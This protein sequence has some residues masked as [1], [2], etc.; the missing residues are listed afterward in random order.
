MTARTLL[1]PCLSLLTLSC[2]HPNRVSRSA[3]QRLS[4][5]RVPF[6]LV[7][8]SVSTPAKA[9]AHPTIRFAHP[10]NTTGPEYTL[11]SLVIGNGDRFFAVLQAQQGMPGLD[12]FYA[13]VG[14]SETGF[15]KVLY[16]RLR[17]A[18]PPTAMYVGEISV[19]PAENR[20]QRDQKVTASFRDDF[21]S[22]AKELKQLYPRFDGEV[23]KVA[24]LRHP[25]PT[26]APPR[27]AQ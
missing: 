7:F 15:D 23:K 1:I 16:V 24:I 18:D 5:A 26:A 14:S 27:R 12:E 17:P 11:W 20:Y 9:L 4:K 2:A 3:L 19:S 22:A 13:E 10:A 21:E 8:G 25:I 6:V